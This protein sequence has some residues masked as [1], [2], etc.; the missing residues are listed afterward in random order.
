VKDLRRSIITAM[1]Q[2]AGILVYRK[3]GAGVEVFI[4]HPGGP[5]WAKK[6]KGAWS[7]PKG[8]F[9]GDEDMQVA[10]R[11]E[12]GE[13]TGQA[14]PEGEHLDLGFVKNKSGKVIYAWAVEGDADAAAL[15]S[16]TFEMEWPPKS[17]QQQSFQEVDKAGWFAPEKAM[18]KLNPAQAPLVER[19]LEALHL[20]IVEPP[21]QASL[22]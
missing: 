14:A 13:E 20:E 3:K 2:S 15:Q 5:F 16:N 8:E 11:R 1:K 6:D 4:V 12:F 17:G 21:Q 19:L 18:E 10:A 22:F 9:T 7:I